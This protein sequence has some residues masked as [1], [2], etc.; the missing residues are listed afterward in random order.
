MRRAAVLVLAAVAGL[1]VGGLSMLALQA[2]AANLP[3][4]PPAEVEG[5][6]DPQAA[7][8][9]ASPSDPV[10][11]PP[12]PV[13]PDVGS[14]LLAWTR[15]GLP[16]G[17]AEQV[18]GLAGVGEV[19]TVAGDVVDLVGSRRADGRVVDDLADGWRVPL[20]VVA[21]DPASYADLMPKGER[22]G[23]RQ[24]AGRRGAAGRDVG[25]PARPR[26]R[27]RAD[28][29]RRPR[30]GGP[31]RGRRHARRCR[32]GR[33]RPR[34]RTA[35]RRRHRPVR[36]AHPPGGP[37]RTRA[38]HPRPDRSRPAGAGARRDAL[39][40]PRRRRA[41]AGAGQGGVRRVRVPVPRRRGDRAGPD[42]GRR[43]RR[44]GRGAGARP[45]D[46]PPQHPRTARRGPRRSRGAGSR[47]PRRP[48][49]VRRLPTPRG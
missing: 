17:F 27:G 34:G 6:D 24:S 32:R 42:L 49:P 30:P 40:A 38:G 44:H 48:R 2:P 43:Q 41:A 16:D 13:P 39:P 33:C 10:I 11:E 19:T 21:I 9:P 26:R 5:R 31:R 36:A 47:P 22:E 18:A 23:P 1:V 12:G 7:T 29:D 14:L 37:G 15:G 45:G 8:P 25:T 46:L 3:D 4:T 20:D 35:A 28:P